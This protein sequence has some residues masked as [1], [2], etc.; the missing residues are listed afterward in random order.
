MLC[1]TVPSVV[2][3]KLLLLLPCMDHTLALDKAKTGTTPGNKNQVT[4][5]G[6][7]MFGHSFLVAMYC[8]IYNVLKLCFT[9][10]V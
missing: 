8:Y 4:N 9:F 6:S 3:L 1:L 2:L 7:L 10:Q 5:L